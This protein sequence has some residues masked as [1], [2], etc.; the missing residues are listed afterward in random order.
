MR[1][2]ALI[3]WVIFF[4][5]SCKAAIKVL[6]WAGVS[7]E[8][9]VREGSL[10]KLTQWLWAGFSSPLWVVELEPHFQWLLAASHPPFLAMRAFST[11]KLLHQSEQAKK[12]IEGVSEQYGSHQICNLIME[13]TFPQCG[14]ILLVRNKLFKGKR[15]HK[16]VNTRR[17]MSLGTILEAAHHIKYVHIYVC[18][19]G[20]VLFYNL[21]QISKMQMTFYIHNSHLYII[22]SDCVVFHWIT[23]M[24]YSP[25]PTTEHEIFFQFLFLQVMLLCTSLYLNI[26]TLIYIFSWERIPRDEWNCWFEDNALFKDL[27]LYEMFLIDLQIKNLLD[28]QE[29]SI[30]PSGKAYFCFQGMPMCRKSQPP[31][32]GSVYSI[33]TINSPY[34][35]GI[36]YNKASISPN[37]LKR[38]CSNL[39]SCEQCMGFICI[40]FRSVI[41]EGAGPSLMK[42][43]CGFYADPFPRC[44]WSQAEITS[45]RGLQNIHGKNGTER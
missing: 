38:S 6:P 29:P 45:V 15:L 16:A 7:S 31:S 4:T 5:A 21:L 9:S 1:N 17:Q 32:G 18:K 34:I 8:C 44:L 3:N 37:C 30:P 35:M 14:K 25:S 43:I 11:W 12:T 22:V 13:L 36:P 19:G 10:S 27:L 40:Y 20:I 42:H 26:S 24:I 28:W 33:L 39:P 2:L 23:V 41:W